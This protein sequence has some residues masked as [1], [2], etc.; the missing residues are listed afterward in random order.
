MHN[1][2]S[3]VEGLWSIVE[4][5]DGLEMIP[6]SWLSDNKNTS[7]WPQ[8][9]SQQRFNKAVQYCLSPEDDWTS[10]KITRILA[11]ASKYITQI[12]C[13]YKNSIIK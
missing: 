12:K 3:S 5:E 7:Y 10:C 8:F 1:P 11:T 9:T 6:S 2:N 13:I 4:F